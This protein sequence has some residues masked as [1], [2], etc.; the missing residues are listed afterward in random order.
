MAVNKSG[1]LFFKT[2]LTRTHK[3]FEC[4]DAN[5]KDFEEA[6]SICGGVAAP[7]P[8]GPFVTPG[9]SISHDV[10]GGRT[11]RYST[12]L[13]GISARVRHHKVAVEHMRW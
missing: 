7:S 1:N 3:I 4:T 8:F 5:V 11:L 9:P 6:E 2:L 12:R 10:D 13:S